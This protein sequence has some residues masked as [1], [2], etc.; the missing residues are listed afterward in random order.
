MIEA[1]ATHVSD[2]EDHRKTMRVRWSTGA[3]VVALGAALCGVVSAAQAHAPQARSLALTPD[4]AA[5]VLSLPGFGL[6][7]GKQAPGSF[8]YLCDAA[9]GQQPAGAPPSL[10]FVADGSLLLGTADG[11]RRVAPDGCPDPHG[12]GSLS[13]ASVVALA[14]QPGADVVYA[15]TG[16]DLPALWR[17]VDGGGTWQRRSTL[18]SAELVSALLVSADDPDTLYM[19]RG[20]ATH[21]SLL[22]SVD[23]GASFAS[24]EQARGLTLLDAR[25]G[26][27]GRFWALARSADNVTNRGFD[28]LHADHLQGPWS[29]AVR[30]NFFGGFSIDA[31]GVV[32]IGDEGGGLHRSDDQGESFA[33][34]AP[35]QAVACLA[36]AGD[37]LW[38]CTP[39]TN[40]QPALMRQGD[41]ARKLEPVVAF[42][43]VDQLVECATDLDVPAQCAAAWVEWRRDVR[44][45]DVTVNDAGSDAGGDA[46]AE[47]PA[48]AAAA[49]LGCSA[50][51]GRA[52]APGGWA[53]LLLLLLGA[54]VRSRAPIES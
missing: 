2:A 25:E 6:L 9:L 19:S 54:R 18:L 43:D 13:A 27:A 44:M 7:L 8:G 26:D 14:G 48:E 47:P 52:D 53:G 33:N 46:A 50:M 1:R 23:G 37:A 39:G 11:L 45:E 10:V 41:G 12:V 3:R 28:L 16:G 40:L 4:G 29:L 17:S 34:V 22:V 49:H 15:A 21:S 38:A 51:S 31:Q 5:L 35:D 32:W 42:A 36:A 24:F 30:V 20:T